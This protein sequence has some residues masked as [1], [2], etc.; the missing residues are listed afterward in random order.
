MLSSFIKKLSRKKEIKKKSQNSELSPNHISYYFNEIIRLLIAHGKHEKF[1][2]MDA[3]YL[4]PVGPSKLEFVHTHIFHLKKEKLYFYDH[5]GEDL[6]EIERVLNEES[7]TGHQ[8]SFS[9]SNQ[10]I[11]NLYENLANDID[12]SHIKNLLKIK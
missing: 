6:W 1:M 10:Q 8:Y 3:W 7:A 9:G 11:I 5:S 4:R 2:Q 12:T